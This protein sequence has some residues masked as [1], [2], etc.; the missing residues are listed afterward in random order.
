MICISAVKM[1][2]SYK[3]KCNKCGFEHQYLTGGGFFTEDYFNESE[4]LEGELKEE[5]AS[6]KYGKILK[7]ML[8]AD[9]DGCLRF[10]CGTEIFQ[11][12]EC[13]ALLVHRE[14]HIGVWWHS[15]NQYDFEVDINQKCPEC[16][17][18]GFKKLSKYN[19]WCPNCKEDVMELI[20][21]G[22]WD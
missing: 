5:V 18:E 9:A 3:Y 21:L 1:G 11:C 6:G 10:S 19:P 22:K 2:T 12:R 4:K 20:S 17:S 15:D 16:G 13:R 7:A 8:A 14:K